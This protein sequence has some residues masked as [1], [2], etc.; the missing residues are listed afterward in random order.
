M[1]DGYMGSGTRLYREKE[2]YGLDNFIKEI[3]EYLPNREALA[4]REKEIVNEDMLKEEL[5]LNLMCGGKGGFISVEQQAY[6][7]S[8]GG[9]ANVIKLLNDDNHRIKCHEIHSKISKG[10]WQNEDFRQNMLLNNPFNNGEYWSGRYHTEETKRKIGDKTKLTQKGELN[11][12]YGTCWI[13]KDNVSKKIKNEE[14]ESYIKDGWI[15][16][17][18]CK[19]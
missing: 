7:S 8:C 11:S 12:Q 9:K 15:K 6:R 16:G 13:M 5:C 2:K 1:D 17:R 10:L 18:K 19:K 3:L 14:L 4:L